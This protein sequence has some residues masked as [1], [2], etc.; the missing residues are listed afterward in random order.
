METLYG[1]IGVPRTRLAG[2]DRRIMP[3][4]SSGAQIMLRV[5]AANQN[6]SVVGSGYARN[7]SIGGASLYT[8]H[9]LTMGQLV[10]VSIPMEREELETELPSHF[11]GT[12]TVLRVNPI[13][14]RFLAVALRF[15]QTLSSDWAYASYIAR[16]CEK[17]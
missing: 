12:A 2:P 13:D 5:P 10:Q 17:H 4:Y 3:R 8:R 14:A 11:D 16:L 6:G 1:S 7:L 15:D 9:R